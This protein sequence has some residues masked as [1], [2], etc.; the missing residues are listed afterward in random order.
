[1]IILLDDL[2]RCMYK[3]L[4]A[5]ED[6]LARI[7]LLID[8]KKKLVAIHMDMW[9]AC[10]ERSLMD[11]DGVYNDKYALELEIQKLELEAKA[12]NER[13]LTHVHG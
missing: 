5:D 10:N 8:Y 6:S 11:A 12:V 3:K 1:M 2:T 4:K 7:H 13:I 9:L